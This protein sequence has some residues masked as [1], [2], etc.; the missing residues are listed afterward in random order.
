MKVQD[1][2][3]AVTV[4]SN[5]SEPAME[6]RLDEN[7][8]PD[9]EKTKRI[10]KGME[11]PIDFMDNDIQ[12]LLKTRRRVAEKTQQNISF[13]HLWLLFQP[14]IIAVSPGPDS[15]L[16]LRAIRFC[17]LLVVAKSST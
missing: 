5:K 4:D 17:T 14:G 8:A 12:K 2:D 7:T 6:R 9:I 3:V 13:E 11:C 1:K 10:I 16:N 15:D